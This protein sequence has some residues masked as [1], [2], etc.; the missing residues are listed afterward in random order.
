MDFFW[1]FSSAFFQSYPW[2]RFSELTHYFALV[3]RI[4]QFVEASPQRTGVMISLL[5]YVKLSAV[6]ARR[7]EVC[8]FLRNGVTPSP[9]KLSVASP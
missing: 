5:T 6:E 8:L 9:S 1:G 4:S 7:F 3:E 2:L